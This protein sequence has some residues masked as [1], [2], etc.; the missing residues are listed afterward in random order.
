LRRMPVGGGRGLRVWCPF[1]HPLR[2]GAWRA[3]V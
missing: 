3:S 2:S 1:R